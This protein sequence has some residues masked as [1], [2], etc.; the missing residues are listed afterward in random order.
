MKVLKLGEIPT[1]DTQ[2]YYNE[3]IPTEMDFSED[4][5]I[6]FCRMEIPN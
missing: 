1:V 3:Y 2:G 5:P 4:W 6:G